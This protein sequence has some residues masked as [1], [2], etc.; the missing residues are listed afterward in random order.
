VVERREPAEQDVENDAQAPEVDGLVV[1]L[2]F[3]HLGRHVTGRTARRRHGLA[4][5]AAVLGQTEIRDLDGTVRFLRQIQQVLRLQVPV[6]NANVVQVR[7][8]GRYVA[9]EIRGLLLGIR[10]F[11]DYPVK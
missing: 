11:G 9:N 5:G 1:R 8:R 4:F 10:P 2:V 3:E 6:H 7:N